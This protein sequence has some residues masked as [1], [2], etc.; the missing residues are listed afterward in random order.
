MKD[1]E[2]ALR[3][4]F[5][6][7]K[8]ATQQEYDSWMESINYDQATYNRPL[9]KTQEEIQRDIC[10]LKIRRLTIDKQLETTR[11]EYASVESQKRAINSIYHELKHEMVMLNPK[12]ELTVEDRNS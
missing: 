10:K 5:A 1:L 3:A 4:K 12:Q 8:C 2:T 9:N 7:K 11:M 6:P